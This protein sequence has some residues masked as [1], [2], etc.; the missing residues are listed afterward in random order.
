MNRSSLQDDQFYR[1]LS[2]L[3]LS[4]TVA[5]LFFVL[6]VRLFYIQIHQYDYHFRLSEKNRIRLKILEAPRGLLLDSRGRVLARNRSAFTINLLPTELKDK[7]LVLENLLKIQDSLGN[8]MFDSAQV[9]F[10]MEKGRWKKFEPLPLLEDASMEVVALVEEHQLDLPGVISTVEG[11]REYPFET[12]AAHALGYTAE[13]NEKE[14]ESL[15]NRGYRQGNRVGVKGLEKRYETLLR[16]KEGKRF[17][18]VNVYGKEV[19]LLKDMPN[20]PAEPG[21]NLVTTL[22]LELQLAAEE[23]FP[24]SIRGG[25]VAIDPR[26]GEVLVMLSSPRLDCNIFSWSRKFR[27]MA[28]RDLALDSARPLN[29]RCVIGLYEP[30]STFKGIVALAGFASGK[31]QPEYRG[32]KACTGGFQF[33]RRYQRCW[34]ET[35]HGQVDFFDAFRQSC[36]VYFYQAGLLLG[37]NLINNMAMAFGFGRITGIDLVSERAGVLMD[38]VF[39]EKKFGSRG[40]RWSRGLILNLAIGQGQ[41]VTPLQ[42]ANYAAGLGNGKVIYKPHLLKEVRD[43][44]GNTLM[45]YEAQVLQRLP[46]SPLE[47][48]QIL[49]AMR[50]VVNDPGGT[51]GRA[52]VPGVI[53]GGKTGSAENPAGKKTHALFIAVAPLARPE[54]AVAV[55]MENAGHG[56]S[57]AAPV[58]CEV[59]K[60]YFRKRS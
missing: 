6:A 45:R 59:L 11:R 58:A 9:A 22:D 3:K 57:V 17:M 2:A 48:K 12:V 27:T 52:R 34:K 20:E 30:G 42:L 55:I 50:Q 43:I 54:I 25:L 31:L 18:E 28:W 26:N 56:G 38:S 49:E 5:V 41:L 47:H 8:K 15:K 33:G 29:N 53:V 32:F 19:A 40:W 21:K 16:G 10:A 51:G 14:L 60:R 23:A 36:D 13:I 35:G 37:M 46:I 39:Y 44:N 4:V 24:D 7:E 1:N